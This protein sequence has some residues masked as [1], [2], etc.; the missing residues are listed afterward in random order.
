MKVSDFG[1]CCTSETPTTASVCCLRP[2]CDVRRGADRRFLHLPQGRRAE[3]TV[4]QIGAVREDGSTS[5]PDRASQ[6]RL[7]LVR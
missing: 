2:E 6:L 3:V 1:D 4:F 5:P 7:R